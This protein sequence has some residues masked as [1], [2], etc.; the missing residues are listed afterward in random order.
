MC[1]TFILVATLKLE[2]IVKRYPRPRSLNPFRRYTATMATWRADFF[3][4]WDDAR[5]SR[6]MIISANSEGEIVEEAESGMRDAVR[7]E[8]IPIDSQHHSPD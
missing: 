8:F 3:E 1:P 4:D 7:L 2:H 6:S 5:P